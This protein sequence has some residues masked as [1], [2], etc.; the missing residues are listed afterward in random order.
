[1]NIKQAAE[2][3][4][5]TTDTLRYYERVGIIPPVTRNE[6][7]YRDF[8]VS[9]LNWVYLVKTLRSAGLSIESLIEF[10]K[11]AQEERTEQ[12]QKAQKSILNEQR[13][14]IDDKIAELQKTRELL[15]YKIDTYDKHIAKFSSQDMKNS[16]EELWKKFEQR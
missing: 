11:L 9:D 6:S 14:E 7:G 3:F 15:S 5:I 1:M 13:D 4:G 16:P 10:S 2:Q 12:V 8:S